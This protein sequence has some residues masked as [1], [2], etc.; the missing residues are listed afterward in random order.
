VRTVAGMEDSDT[1]SRRP[2]LWVVVVA[3]LL[4]F[5]A[6]GSCRTLTHHEALLAGSA[7]QMVADGR[8]LV[9]YIG[10]IPRLEKP[11]LPQWIVA[12]WAVLLGEFS[13]WTVRMPF[14]VFGVLV[15][16]LETILM[17]RLFDTRIG[18]WCGLI[19]ATCVY[20]M[21]HAR[22]AE[23]DIILQALVL[24]A[25]LLFVWREQE[26]AAWTPRQ[27]FAA[28]L[29]FWALLGAMNLLKGVGFGP[30]LTLLTC[31]G[32]FLLRRDW[33]GFARW[34]SWPGLLLAV[35]IGLAWPATVM[36]Y[37]PVGMTVW[38]NQILDRAT[39]ALGRHQPI[40]YYALHWPVQL[41]PWTPFLFVGA[42]ASWKRARTDASGPDRWL[43]W[44]ALS[45]PLLL[46]LSSG[47][48]HHYLIYALP[49]LTPIM[50]Q[51]LF[52]TGEAWSRRW[53]WCRSPFVVR[54]AGPALLSVAVIAHLTV[55][56]IVLPW[57]DPSAAD[58]EFLA[59]VEQT[60]PSDKP[61][62]AF[63][64][65]DIARHVFYL[66]RPL[67]GISHT[68]KLAALL[69]ESDKLFVIARGT[70]EF[71]LNT[72]G[73]AAIVLQ[74]R[75]TRREKSAQDRYTLFEVTRRKTLAAESI[76]RREQ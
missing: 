52:I 64:G 62:T 44:W 5:F 70:S 37:E 27:H 31:G 48:H 54:F 69:H 43:W 1:F 30:I 11:P 75:S 73:D 66:H 17:T 71:D 21:A 18:V 4:F 13:E 33:S 10:D 56:G 61:L 39:G 15:I 12:A 3:S 32:W 7:K 35:L 59:E 72:V 38:Q 42:P 74:S 36:Y 46:S 26:S 53:E 14:A 24:G 57:R 40:W 6:L 41:L 2:L 58:A 60:V 34:W 20:Q 67:T 9:L 29:G 51:G 55:Q 16:V 45:H 49:A 47:K 65:Q 23:S 28:K 63:G 68:D 8:W 50:V 19:Q 76:E 25:V 22:L